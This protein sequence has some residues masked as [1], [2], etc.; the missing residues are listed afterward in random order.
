M[1]KY[2]SNQLP[3]FFLVGAPKAGTTS[4]YRYL[5]QHPEIFVPDIKEPHYFSYPEVADTYYD[6]RIVKTF[7]EYRRLFR[8]AEPC[9]Q[10]GDFS[11]S[12]LYHKGAA[13]RIADICP[14]A[15]VLVSLR[16]PVDR[17]ISHYL[18]DVRDGYQPGPLMSYINPAAREDRFFREY[19]E[20]GQYVD[21]VQRYLSLFGKD[22]VFI[23]LFEEFTADPLK[24]VSAV[25]KFLD[26]KMDSDLDT[27]STYNKFQMY[28]GATARRIAKSDYVQTL[29]KL[30]PSKLRSA[31]RQLFVTTRKPSFDEER[32]QLREIYKEEIIRL[33]KIIDRDLSH[34]LR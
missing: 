12:Y 31:A 20:V 22:R 4:M 21:Q 32:E 28:R 19:I 5:A 7:E 25:L 29:S 27:G 9:Q 23:I 2:N 34:W 16:N 26:L 24:S 13:H 18:M 8:D 3:D 1:N 17:A 33:Q 10:A 11:T 6:T 14:D 15:R 30:L